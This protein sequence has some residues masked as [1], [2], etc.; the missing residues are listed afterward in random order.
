[1]TSVIGHQVGRIA[2]AGPRPVV[3]PPITTE[4]LADAMRLCD[5]ALAALNAALTA[6]EKTAQ[7]ANCA[8]RLVLRDK[9]QPQRS[10][11]VTRDGISIEAG[12]I[13]AGSAS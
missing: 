9:N 7:A 6:L 10:L 8:A 5:G 13:R 1:M 2:T 3:P 4:G 12:L 11:V